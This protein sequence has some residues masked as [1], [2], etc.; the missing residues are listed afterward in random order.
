MFY[1]EDYF[2]EHELFYKQLF[3]GMQ[4]SLI[5]WII[6]KEPTHGY[7][8]M[9]QLDELF[10][11]QIER[12]VMKKATNSRIYPLLK[13]MEENGVISSFTGT[14]NN[15]EVKF[16]EI[17]SVGLEALD[18]FKEVWS[19]LLKN[20]LWNEFF[21]DISSKFFSKDDGSYKHSNHFKK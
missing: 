11:Y 4:K 8:I 2:K 6:S 7:A 12:G 15:R 20:D 14:H 19:H 1:D 18:D 3:A 10:S 9:K 16:Y 5:V 21:F 17:T 13:Q